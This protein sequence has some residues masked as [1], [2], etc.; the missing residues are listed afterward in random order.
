MA[1]D[2]YLHQA[3]YPLEVNCVPKSSQVP[4]HLPGAVPGRIKML[5]VDQA[6]QFRFSGY[7][8]SEKNHARRS[9]ARS[10]RAIL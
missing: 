2:H 10:W 9:V 8:P 5:F 3:A 4:N 1:D 6:H 7:L